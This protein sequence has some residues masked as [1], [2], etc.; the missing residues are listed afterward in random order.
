MVFVNGFL[1][2]GYTPMTAAFWGIVTSAGVHVITVILEGWRA[3]QR[4]HRMAVRWIVDM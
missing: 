1:L 2:E 4:L 3:R